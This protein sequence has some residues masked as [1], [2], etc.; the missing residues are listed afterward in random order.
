METPVFNALKEKS[1]KN[2]ISFHTPGHKGRNALIDWSKYIPQMDTTE[3]EGLDNLLD[4]DGIIKESQE[5]AS[6][7]YKTRAT[8]YSVNGST[9]S[10]YIGLSTITKPGDK[11][12]IQRN[13][14]KSIYNGIIL[15]SLEPVYISPNYN[16]KHN[17]T[18]GIDLE[19]LE[20][21]LKDHRDIKA[22][23][24]T[25]PDYYGICCHIE[26]IA[27]IAHKYDAILMVDEAHGSHFNFSKDLPKSSIELG[28]DIVVQSIHK[29]LPSLTQTSLIHV[30][31]DR[32]DL[33]ELQKNY[34]L[35]TTTSPS[36]LFIISCEAAIAY[37]DD[38]RDRLGQKL[39]MVKSLISRLESLK[40]VN[41]FSKDI[42]DPSI[43]DKDISKILL[44]VDGYSGKE[45][46][47]ILHRDYFIDM[48]MADPHYALALTSIMNDDND[49][50]KL[51]DALKD[52]ANRG[53]HGNKKDLL[54]I[55]PLPKEI[56]KISPSIA[57]HMDTENIKLE[58]SLGRI[59][60]STII[61][62]PPGIP[63]IV[64]GELI[65]EEI[66]NYISY[67]KDLNIAISGFLGYNKEYI[68]VTK[69]RCKIEG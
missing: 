58:N 53:L 24:I 13:S 34:Q 18:T 63:L 60:G 65:S 23:I 46:L 14:H 20:K 6:K 49:Y 52:I 59:S 50:S 62:Y 37:M 25:Y 21:K 2:Y 57:Y 36:Y 35:Y 9:G 4:P 51:Y 28:A 31:S 19:E 10:I 66:I 38:N 29:T 8:Y 7:V 48:E 39:T 27:E 1:K 44:S 5:A 16:E 41:L 56:I 12:L 67:L 26:K 43:N 69:E 30:C 61:P 42:D 40:G 47:D 15:N 32:I 33:N 17:I 3:I 64:P 55:K 68:R 54:K 45:L 22:V 11:V